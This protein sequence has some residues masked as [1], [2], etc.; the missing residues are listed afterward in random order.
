MKLTMALRLLSTPVLFGLAACSGGS[1]ALPQH[2]VQQRAYDRASHPSPIQHVIIVLQENRTVDNL[3]NGFPGADTQNW[4]YDS[5]GQAVTFRPNPLEWKGDICHAHACFTQAYDSGKMDGFN[6]ENTSVVYCNQH[7]ICPYSAVPQ[8]ESAPYW[9]MAEQYVFGD[10]MFSEQGP[11]FPAHQ[12]IIGGGSEIAAGSNTYM[13]DNP[14]S[15]IYGN[16]RASGCDAVSGS[17]VETLALEPAGASEG[18]P[19]FPCVD[20][21][22]LSDLLDAAG[23]SWRY[24]QHRTGAGLWNAF[25]AI[26]H[27]RYGP[28][29]TNVVSPSQTILSDISA[30]RLAQVSWVMPDGAHSDHSGPGAGNGGPSW[31]AAIVNAIGSSKYWQNTAIVVTWDDWGGWYDH[32]TPPMI[33][34][35][36]LGFRVPLIV[37]SPYAKRGYVSHVQYDFGSILR[38]V[39]GTYGLPSLGTTD[40]TANDLGDCFDYGQL[41][42]PFTPIAAPPFSPTGGA[43]GD[44]EDP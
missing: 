41:P 37:I 43:A 3:F 44:R 15:T 38:Y 18:N 12:F 39:E 10:R 33:D 20:H 1:P 27:V 14:G 32:V 23:V 11:S 25:D 17:V 19:V 36:D 2:G 8:S 34:N 24:Y 31:V 4:G 5:H 35:Y 26:R 29:Y 16:G 30:G 13:A 42:R 7:G 28:D 40:A 21:Q 9:A 22:V 6:Q